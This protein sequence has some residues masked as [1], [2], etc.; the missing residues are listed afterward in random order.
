MNQNKSRNKTTLSYADIL[1][2]KIETKKDSKV[3]INQVNIN[4][5]STNQINQPTKKRIQVKGVVN[6][7]KNELIKLGYANFEDWKSDENNLYIG[8]DMSFYVNGAV[9]SVWGNPFPVAKKNN[10]YK[11]KAP[12]YTLDESLKKYRQHIESNPELVNRLK[13]LDGKILGCWCKPNGCHGDIL[14]E[15]VDKYCN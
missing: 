14:T 8:R 11:N 5:M 13:E 1:K 3:S 6:V 12:R 2:S 9:G 15:L 4:Q 7:R 10:D